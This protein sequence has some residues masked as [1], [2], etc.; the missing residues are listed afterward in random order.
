MKTIGGKLIPA[1]MASASL[2]ALCLAGLAM[3]QATRPSTAPVRNQPAQ[4]QPGAR[5]NLD[6][7]LAL[8]VALANDNEIVLAKFAQTRTDNKDVQKFAESLQKDHEQFA[9]ELQRFA[10]NIATLRDHRENRSADGRRDPER[11]AD[12]EAGAA[13]RREAVPP[14]EAA[15]PRAGTAPGVAEPQAAARQT[16]HMNVFEQIKLELADTCLDSAQRALQEE[17][18]A[19]FDKCYVGMQ[20]GAHMK[21]I[22][23]LKVFE[24][25]SS[26]ELQKVL[27]KGLQTSQKHLEAARKLMKDVDHI[28]TA[29]RDKNS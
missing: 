7:H 13:E 16:A 27:N 4:R 1:S 24:K 6:P 19:E 21:M 20:L 10:G 25:H 17:K 12:A 11:P 2:V 15:A 26:P 3:A 28:R 23:T 22:D 29:S 5:E 9:Q 8:E 14:R 18:G